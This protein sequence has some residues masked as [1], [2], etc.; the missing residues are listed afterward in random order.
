MIIDSFKLYKE[1]TIKIKMEKLENESNK[2]ILKLNKLFTDNGINI[3]SIE[4]K[5]I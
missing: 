1:Y 4:S 5:Q 3:F 2:Y